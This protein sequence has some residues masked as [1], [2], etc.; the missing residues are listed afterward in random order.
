MPQTLYFM[1]PVRYV[2]GHKLG[3]Y[4]LN[5]E[6]M[7]A[8][9]KYD[10]TIDTHS[11]Y[12]Q[13]KRRKS[14]ITFFSPHECIYHAQKTYNTRIFLDFHLYK[15]VSDSFH[16]APFSILELLYR[17]YDEGTLFHKLIKEY[18][19]PSGNWVLS[20][21]LCEYAFVVSKHNVLSNQDE[22]DAVLFSHQ[23]DLQ[24]ARKMFNIS[25]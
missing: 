22:L 8:R 23:S 9:K 17:H 12:P 4:D 14:V 2:P 11:P 18:W 13:I 16:R 15:V 1:S 21:F 5:Y 20:E 10:V 19:Q 7:E 3:S 6:E 25:N 24:S